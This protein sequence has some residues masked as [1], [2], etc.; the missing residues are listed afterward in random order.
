MENENL[1][2]SLRE[3]VEALFTSH[4][5]AHKEHEQAHGRE[6]DFSQKA[7]DV[8]ASL[9]KENKADANE[10]RETMND[11]ERNFTTKNEMIAIAERVEKLEDSEIARVVEEKLTVER[12]AE[13]SRRED[14]E[15]A[16]QQ[17]VIATII[18]IVVFLAA[19]I[20]RFVFPT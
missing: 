7:I 18:G 10:W 17:W 9:A 5:E 4:K 8:A 3:Y 6:H 15:R 20:S 1:G 12:N 13:N 14:R 16:R 19:Q 11:R 2:P